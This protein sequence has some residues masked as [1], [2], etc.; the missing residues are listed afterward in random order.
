MRRFRVL[1]VAL[2]VIGLAAAVDVSGVWSVS[3]SFEWLPTLTCSLRQD[4]GS[5]ISGTCS[6]GS[7]S[8]DIHGGKISDTSVEWTFEAPHATPTGASVVYS[9]RGTLS[10]DALQMKG[11]V[12]GA[13]QSRSYPD[14]HGTFTARRR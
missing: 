7:T 3:V 4:K 1:L 13:D 2:L 10:S 9:F 6:S 14:Q 8:V 5:G 11:T 12:V